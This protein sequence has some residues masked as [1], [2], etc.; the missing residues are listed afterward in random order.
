AR[1]A[2]VSS[3]I[4][5]GEFSYANRAEGMLAMRPVRPTPNTRTATA[6][7]ER[8]R[9]RKAC[10]RASHRLR[11]LRAATAVAIPLLSAPDDGDSSRTPPLCGAISTLLH[12]KG[13]FRGG[14]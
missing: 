9:A 2:V 4:L 10:R 12:A 8:R 1:A 7:F 6:G 11:P 5:P 13:D 3:A 14:A